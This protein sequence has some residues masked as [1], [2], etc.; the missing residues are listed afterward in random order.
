MGIIGII[1]TVIKQSMFIATVYGVLYFM[2]IVHCTFKIF[3]MM[4][5]FFVI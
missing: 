2:F 5:Y 3:M 4:S 1:V